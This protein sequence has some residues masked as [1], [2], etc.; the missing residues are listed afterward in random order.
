MMKKTETPNSANWKLL[1]LTGMLSAV[2]LSGCHE[3]HA[4]VHEHDE[5]ESKLIVTRPLKKDTIVTRDYVCQ[6]HSIQNIEIRALE[7]GYL[8]ATHV[9][10]GQRIK[11]GAP[12]FKILPLVYQAELRK[13]E[14]EARVAE[15]KYL[16]TKRLA[17]SKVVSEQE[18]AIAKAE[19]EKAQAEVNLAQ[20]HLGFTNIKAPFS[21][22]LDRLLVR[23]GSLVEEGD[24]LTTL[25]DNSEMWVYFNV[26]E[27]EYLDY[28]SQ[29][30]P[31]ERKAVELVMANGATFRHRGKIN[32]IEAEFNNQTG[33]IMFRAD[34]PNPE[35]LLRHGE[36]GNIQMKKLVKGALLIPQKCT[37]EILDHHYVFVVD[38]DD[39][40]S[41]Q[42]IQIEEELEDLFIVSDGLNENDK[43][44][45][46]GLRH[47]RNGEKAQ[48]EFEEPAEAIKHLKLRAE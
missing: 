26:P 14:A 7:R 34:F 4:E 13:A 45:L 24:L 22:L 29:E 28:V 39:I 31:E 33:T 15:V 16:N 43:I 11:E 23:Q 41:Q 3:G 46:E 17:D 6:I 25:S 37:Y 8:D 38:K 48:Y 18:L 44:V 19:L 42:R 1:M 35:G 10:E 27:A 5:E 9:K 30:Q 40:V 47:A 12:M 32:A 21:G 36:T 2:L 20:T